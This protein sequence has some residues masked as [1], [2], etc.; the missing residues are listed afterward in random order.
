MSDITGTTDIIVDLVE[1]VTELPDIAPSSRFETMGNW[2]SLS[3]LRLLTDIEDRF[4]VKLDLRAYFAVGDVDQLS[5]LV[6]STM[7]GR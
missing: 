3:A 6:A 4:G 5:T 2:T 1:R 7:V